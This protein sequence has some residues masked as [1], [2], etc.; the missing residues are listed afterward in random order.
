MPEA[1]KVTLFF[2]L[3][4]S[5]NDLFNC[6][7]INI[8]F[9]KTFT[10]LLQNIQNLEGLWLAVEYAKMFCFFKELLRWILLDKYEVKFSVNL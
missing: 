7:K 9:A 3:N 6:T 5:R 1:T 2:E 8:I 4:P 10:S